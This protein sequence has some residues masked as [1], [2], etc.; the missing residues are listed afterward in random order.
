MEAPLHV[1]G[2]CVNRIG[3]VQISGVDTPELRGKCD[4]ER[5]QA[6]AARAFVSDQLSGGTVRLR[7]IHYGKYAGRVVAR[8][9]L[10]DGR[11]LADSLIEAGLGRAYSGGRRRPWCP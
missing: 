4:H 8:I 11:D 9:V 3:T 7:D 2:V 5:R 6:E 1:A 10:P